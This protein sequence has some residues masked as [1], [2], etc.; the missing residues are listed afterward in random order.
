M[1]G[2]N[3]QEERDARPL[4]PCPVCLRNLCWNL[5]AEPVPYLTKLKA[6]CRQNGLDP[7]SRWY[8]GALAALAT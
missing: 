1:N 2:S 7:E 3:H 5:R 8:E 6:F 4:H